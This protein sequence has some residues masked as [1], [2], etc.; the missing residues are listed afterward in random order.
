MLVG[1]LDIVK[2]S[3][4]PKFIYRLNIT[5]N[6]ISA[7]CRSENEEHIITFNNTESHKHVGQKKPDT[8]GYIL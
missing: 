4:F 5:P 3:I 2:L 6:K 1:K 7:P 8:K